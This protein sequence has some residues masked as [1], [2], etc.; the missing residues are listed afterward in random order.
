MTESNSVHHRSEQE[1]DSRSIPNNSEE[2]SSNSKEG[3]W[4]VFRCSFIASLASLLA[5]MMAGFTS[6]ALL[7]L[8][9]ENLTI[10]LQHLNISSILPSAFGVSDYSLQK[11]VTTLKHLMRKPAK[12]GYNV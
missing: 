11:V 9:N 1:G 4:V 7:E 8:S 10:P 5:G 12:F 3:L 6:P 2:S